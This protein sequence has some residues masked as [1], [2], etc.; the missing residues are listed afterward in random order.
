MKQFVV[1]KVA[2]QSS[3]C[4]YVVSAR[5]R[6]GGGAMGGGAMETASSIQSVQTVLGVAWHCRG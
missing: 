4:R 5:L 3:Q 1:L 2:T 6:P